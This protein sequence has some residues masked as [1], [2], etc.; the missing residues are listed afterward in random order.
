MQA[1]YLPSTIPVLAEAAD[2]PFHDKTG[3]INLLTLPHE[4][5]MRGNLFELPL[6]AQKSAFPV[7]GEDGP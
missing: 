6:Q 1:G 7:I 2:E 3:V 5:C 4:V